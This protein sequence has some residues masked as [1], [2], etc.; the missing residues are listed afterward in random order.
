MRKPLGSALVFCVFSP[1]F[2]FYLG[3]LLAIFKCFKISSQ[4][5]GKFFLTARLEYLKTL[6]FFSFR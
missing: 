1:V 6:I 2:L 5:A 4:T 3:D